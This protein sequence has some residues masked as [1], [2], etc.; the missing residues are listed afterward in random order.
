MQVLVSPAAERDIRRLSPRAAQ[1][2][3]AALRALRDTP[4]PQGSLLLR[5]YHPPTWRIRV[6]DWRI[7]YEINDD[8][9]VVLITGVRHRSKAY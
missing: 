4:R 9:G 3:F 2:I 7:L 8:A 6:G 1:R 5:N